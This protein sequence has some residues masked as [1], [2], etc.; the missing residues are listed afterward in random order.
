MPPDGPTPFNPR[1]EECLQELRPILEKYLAP[2]SSGGMSSD[3]MRAELI[4][5]LGGTPPALPAPK[6]PVI[7]PAPAPVQ[8]AT[9]A[10]PPSVLPG[11]AGGLSISALIGALMGTGT[12][13]TPFEMGQAPTTAGTLAGIAALITPFLG[14]AGAGGT[15][16]SVGRGLIGWLASKA[17]PAK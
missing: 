11:L 5:L 8:P 2:Q 14:A 4:R 3:D 12:I 15:L 17:A 6:P 7:D 16:L 9:P 1:V 10:A 13:G